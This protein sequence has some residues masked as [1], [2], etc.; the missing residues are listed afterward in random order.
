MGDPADAEPWDGRQRVLGGVGPRRLGLGRRQLFP[1][2]RG[3]HAGGAQMRLSSMRGLRAA[4]AFGASAVLLSA[5]LPAGAV[6]NRQP[7]PS[8]A[9]I[10]DYNGDGYGDLAITVTFED[11]GAVFSAGAVS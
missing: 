5:A 8:S 4:L 11:A 7:A 9:P 3:S 2:A 6:P 10:V 1:R